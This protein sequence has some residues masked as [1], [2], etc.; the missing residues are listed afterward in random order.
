MP[1]YI[2]RQEQNTYA[3]KVALILSPMHTKA[4]TWCINAL[5][6]SAVFFLNFFFFFFWCLQNSM[7]GR[8]RRGDLVGELNLHIYNK[9][10]TNRYFGSWLSI[11]VVVVTLVVVV[12]LS[13]SPSMHIK[14]YIYICKRK[15]KKETHA[16]NF[17][18]AIQ[19]SGSSLSHS[20]FFR[21]KRGERAALFILFF[22]FYSSN[23]SPEC[24]DETYT[25][26]CV[27]TSSRCFAC[28]FLFLFPSIYTHSLVLLARFSIVHFFFQLST[29]VHY[30]HEFTPDACISCDKVP[31]VY[32]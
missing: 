28:F 4:Y 30:I 1:I 10:A 12:S 13:A 9:H 23:P 29:H 20:I 5:L 8:E 19:V 31:I 18:T 3:D 32:M 6:K 21:A 22:F 26:F 11:G 17:Y 25:S 16:V 7:E 27:A 14:I 2:H 15:E 24:D